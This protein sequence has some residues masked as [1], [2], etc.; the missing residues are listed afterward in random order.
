[1]KLK[2]LAIAGM[3]TLAT[4]GQAAAQEYPQGQIR[5][6]SPYAAGGPADLMGRILAE[7]LQSELGNIAILE[8]KGGAGGN[9]GSAEVAHAAADGLT[10]LLAS[11]TIFTINPY[12]FKDLPYDPR[13]DL[14]PVAL[15]GYSTLALSVNAGIGVSS[16]EDLIALSKERPIKFSSGGIGSPGHFAAERFSVATGVPIVHVP[17]KGGSP[18]ALAVLSGEVD[19]SFLSVAVTK[20][21]IDSGAVKG[22]AM[23]SAKRHPLLPDMPTLREL[24]IENADS[25]LAYAVLVPTATPQE[26]V[27]M[28]EGAIEKI[29]TKPE[30]LDLIRASGIDPTFEPQEKAVEWIDSQYEAM[31]K[32][33]ATTKM[34]QD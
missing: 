9:T 8:S 31:G 10:V 24:G 22:I 32:I 26:T 3:L 34:V 19:A 11:E 20:P 27:E 29:F 17:Y 14:V 23:A 16:M 5:V 6:I 12:I 25:Q 4:L 21:N 33:V 13:A 18:A 2:N 1:M 28:L 15:T 7:G 30:N